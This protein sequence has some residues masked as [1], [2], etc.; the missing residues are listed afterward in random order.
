MG[1][2]APSASGPPAQPT[3]AARAKHR[4]PE[5]GQTPNTPDTPSA[6]LRDLQRIQGEWALKW[7]DTETAQI[8]LSIEQ[9]EFQWRNFLTVYQGTWRVAENTPNGYVIEFAATRKKETTE[10]S[11]HFDNK[12]GVAVPHLETKETTLDP[13]LVWSYRV[14][15]SEK[16]ISSTNPQNGKRA[17]WLDH[18]GVI[19]AQPG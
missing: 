11:T 4:Q 2:T 17:T 19:D 10:S 18:S 12:G 8:V 7:D 16:V 1:A 6:S 14:N 13:P 5:K 9:H 3:P 15:L